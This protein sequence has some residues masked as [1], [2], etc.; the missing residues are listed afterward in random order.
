M[1]VTET[2]I[3]PVLAYLPKNTGISIVLLLIDRN[4]SWPDGSIVIN[5]Q[6][7][8][9]NSSSELC[10]SIKTFVLSPHAISFYLLQMS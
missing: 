10:T 4:G 6:A 3:S 2:L 8:C 1:A 9:I 7:F 5:I